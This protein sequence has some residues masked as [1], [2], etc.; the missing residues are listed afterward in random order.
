MKLPAIPLF[1]P[2]VTTYTVSSPKMP[3]EHLMMDSHRLADSFLNYYEKIGFD[4]FPVL[5]ESTFN[6]EAFGCRIGYHTHEPFVVDPLHF[7]TGEAG[8]QHPVTDLSHCRTIRVFLGAVKRIS[9][10]AR[11]RGPVIANSTA[12]LTT[13]SQI[14]GLENMLRKMIRDPGVILALV[15][16]VTDLIVHFLRHLLDAGAHMIFVADPVAS[17]ALISPQMFRR[18]ALPGLKRLISAI[19][20]L[21]ILHIC[22]DIIPIIHDMMEIEFTILSLDQCIRLKK[23]RDLLGKEP[24]LGGNIDPGHVLFDKTPDAVAEAS[25][26]CFKAGGPENFVLMP[27]CTIIPGTPVKNIRSMMAVAREMHA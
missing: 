23:V 2:I 14:I 13:V 19:P 22:G 26:Q 3:L 4:C 12:P 18:F 24:V 16:K 11:G 9:G 20:C 10:V 21:T 1:I 5:G 6:A 27:G 25:R 7:S 17:P 15:D 8:D